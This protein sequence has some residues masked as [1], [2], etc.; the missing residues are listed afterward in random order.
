MLDSWRWRIGPSPLSIL[1][2]TALGCLFLEGDD[3]AV[4]FLDTTEGTFRRVAESREA[5][6]KLFESSEN[7]RALLWSFFVRELRQRGVQL[8]E[9][10]CYGWKVPP[11]LGGEP[12]F[13]NV[14]PTDAAAYVSTQGQ[15]HEQLRR[16]AP[17]ELV[18]E[19]RVAKPSILR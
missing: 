19:M 7:R 6:E 11:G 18:E 8:G 3:G 14:E 15:V 9:R 4:F 5:F 2:V 12:Y 1:H 17:G 13:D 10:Q 16:I